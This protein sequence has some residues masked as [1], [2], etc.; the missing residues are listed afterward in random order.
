MQNEVGV[1]DQMRARSRRRHLVWIWL[2]VA[3]VA[4]VLTLLGRS[5]AAQTERGTDIIERALAA[6]PNLR[7]GKALYRKFCVSCHGGSA[8]GNPRAVV[9][10]LAGQLPLYLIKQLADMAEGDRTVAEMH[11]VIARQQLTTPQAIRDVVSYLS[12]LAPNRRPELGDGSQLALGKRYYQGLCAFCHGSAGEGNDP[13][14]TPALQRQHYS[15]LLMQM[16]Q[17]AVG[18]RYTVD[19]EI[20]QTLEALPFDYL[21]AIADYASRLPAD[22]AAA[23]PA[24]SLPSQLP[25]EPP[26]Q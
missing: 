26:E 20:I 25:E 14:A 3:V 19:I 7:N 6:T 21:T 15:Y 9:P 13:H 18:H 12:Q 22:S 1:D 23:Q 16:R 11:R 8:H 10:A 4:M 24:G 17:L 2:T 5:V